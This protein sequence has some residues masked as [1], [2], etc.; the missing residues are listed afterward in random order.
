MLS[1]WGHSYTEIFT[2]GGSAI[3]LFVVLVQEKANH[4]G[5][6]AMWLVTCLAGASR[7]HFPSQRAGPTTPHLSHISLGLSNLTESD[8]LFISV[9]PGL[10]CGGRLLLNATDQGSSQRSDAV[11]QSEG[12]LLMSLLFRLAGARAAESPGH[13][14]V[15]SKEASPHQHSGHTHNV[16]HGQHRAA[17]RHRETCGGHQTDQ[18]MAE[19]GWA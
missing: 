19:S 14:M 16:L 5:F 9:P 13:R 3:P 18:L 11:V 12:H 2:Q 17:P 15:P 1:G 10:G 4:G 6:S 8:K 7:P